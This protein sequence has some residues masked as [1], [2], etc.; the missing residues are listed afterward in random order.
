MP[1]SNVPKALWPKM[2]RCVTD[3]QKKG[4]TKK[5]AIAICYTSIVSKGVEDVARRRKNGG[6]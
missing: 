2:E 5:E 4:H 1:W 3:V 6:R